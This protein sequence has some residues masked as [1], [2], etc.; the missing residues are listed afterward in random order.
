MCTDTARVLSKCTTLKQQKEVSCTVGMTIIGAFPSLPTAAFPSRTPWVYVSRPK[1]LV[2]SEV[3]RSRITTNIPQ[4]RM[5]I[6][7]LEGNVCGYS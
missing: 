4:N 2:A 1:V 6:R 3:C 7:R 5:S